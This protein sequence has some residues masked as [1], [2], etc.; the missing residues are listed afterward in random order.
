MLLAVCVAVVSRS[1]EFTNYYPFY[2]GANLSWADFLGWELMYAA[3]FFALEFFFRGF[4]I[5]GL[6]D[7]LGRQAIF[8][9]VVPYV[10]IHFGKPFPET[11][12]AI[13]AGSVLGLVS[14]RTGSI[15][16]GVLVHVGVAWTM[17]L[18]SLLFRG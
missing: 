18:G 8:A 16:G 17:D 11:L 9:M 6:K 15:A 7:V 14:L 13:L 2:K 4:F 1:P 5:H 3:Q 12:G 10:M